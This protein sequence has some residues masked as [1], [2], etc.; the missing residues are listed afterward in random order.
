MTDSSEAGLAVKL[1]FDLASFNRLAT[2]KP[3]SIRGSALRYVIGIALIVAYVALCQCS[4]ADQC[5][6]ASVHCQEESL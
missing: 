5:K 4:I 3:S 1:V 2:S 6:G